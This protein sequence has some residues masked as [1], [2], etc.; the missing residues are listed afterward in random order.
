[1][2]HIDEIV[3]LDVK[4]LWR[5]SSPETT[6]IYDF[7]TKVNKK[8]GSSLHDYNAL[9]KWSVSEPAQFWEEIW[10]YTKI[11]VHDPYHEVSKFHLNLDALSWTRDTRC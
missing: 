6:Q 4:E 10:H 11:N 8:Y 2:P 9:W 1:M 3:E 5:P 7:M